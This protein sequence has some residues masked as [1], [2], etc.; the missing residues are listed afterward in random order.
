M[1]W[2][3]AILEVK[4]CCWVVYHL[5]EFLKKSRIQINAVIAQVGDER[6]W[7]FIMDKVM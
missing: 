7:D 1:H 4:N 3:T 2:K 5:G 6:F